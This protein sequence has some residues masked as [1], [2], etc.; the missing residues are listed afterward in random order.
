MYVVNTVIRILFKF[1]LED[2]VICDHSDMQSFFYFHMSV[3][4]N[5][6]NAFIFIYIHGLL[7]HLLYDG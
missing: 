4:T 5:S 2:H 6:E 1:E 7:S 3:I